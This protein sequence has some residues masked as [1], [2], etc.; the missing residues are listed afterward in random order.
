MGWNFDTSAFNKSK[1]LGQ[2][3]L[4]S[5][6]SSVHSW[7]LIRTINYVHI[8]NAILYEFKEISKKT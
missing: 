3:I 5:S 8:S 1:Y 4:S 6:N 7:F 2:N